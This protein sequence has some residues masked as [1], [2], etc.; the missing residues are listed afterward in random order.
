MALNDSEHYRRNVISSILST[1]N[2]YKII[3]IAHQV[4]LLNAPD[5]Q[6][7]FQTHCYVLQW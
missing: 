4:Y 7:G 2:D 1:I 6:F 3:I 5:Y